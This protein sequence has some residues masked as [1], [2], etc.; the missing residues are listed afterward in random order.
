MKRVR[1]I[2]KNRV[3]ELRMNLGFSQEE[4]SRRAGIT[5][6]YLSQI[7][8]GRYSP[9]GEV[10]LRLASALGVSLNEIFFEESVQHDTQGK[11][12]PP[13]ATGTEG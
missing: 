2:P 4:L 5:R 10:L 3:R 6:S 1:A 9:T 8:N 12:N 11:E 7:E 13:N